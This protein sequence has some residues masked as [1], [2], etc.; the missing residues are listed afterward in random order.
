VV[1]SVNH[2][3]EPIC[4]EMEMPTVLITGGHGG[5]GFECA[6]ELAT[7][8]HCDLI[9]AGRSQ[10][11]MTRAATEL[12]EISNVQVTLLQL[13][14]SSLASVRDAVSQCR[15]LL[16]IGAVDTLQAIV[17]NAGRRFLDTSYSVDGYEQTFATNCLGHFLL[18]ELLVNRVA[19]DGRIVFTAS[20]THDPETTDGKMVGKAV[21][22]N[23]VVLASTGKD[24]KKPIPS[25]KRYS[26]SKL[27]TVLYSYEIARRLR[28]SRNSIASIAFDPGS[29]PG[30]GFLRA[31]P[32]PVQL[33][34]NSRFMRWVTKSL[35]VT[36]GDLKFS[37]ASLARL[38][39]DSS[40]QG[41]SGKYFQ[42]N[43]L[44][45]IERRSS[46]ASYDDQLALKLW[47]DSKQLAHL[48]PEEEPALLQ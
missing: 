34:A 2:I 8:Y 42:S 6:K 27:C 23:A 45:L 31:L 41:A 39:A 19:P 43:D 38:A 1:D 20:G 9:L 29:V 17:C 48:Q 22:P 5:I 44:R 21:D 46:T 18:V 28:K 33:L 25:G 7:V 40:F 4:E 12:H 11:G 37:G 47:N 14:T 30:T 24:G 32:T 26:T 16:D 13:D 35:G 36:S 3:S 10:E 15:R